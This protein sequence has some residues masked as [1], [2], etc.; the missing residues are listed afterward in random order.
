LSNPGAPV[1][2]LSK[3]IEI[4]TGL[5]VSQIMQELW[6]GAVVGALSGPTL[7]AEVDKGL[8]T[9]A[10]VAAAS[11]TQAAEFQK[12]LHQPKF[13]L[14]RSTDIP[15]VEMGGALKNVYAIAGGV[16]MGAGLGE[17]AF[18]GLMTRCLAEMTRI[19][20]KAGG[21]PETFSGLSGVGDLLLTAQSEQSRNHRVGRLLAAGKKLETA[22]KEAGGT[23]EG[24]HTAKAV[25][26][27]S[28]IPID[29]KPIL[30]QIHALLYEGK[31]VQK[32]IEELLAR[33]M[34]NEIN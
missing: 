32:A 29:S 3:G 9:V 5:R 8:P 18:A 13:R 15:G 6:P 20:V 25:F 24:V 17:N 19:G 12:L 34:K 7:A 23:V 16:C 14:Y 4:A 33:E 27:N 28:G 1:L 10:V 22:V 21:K 30:A 2:S 11:D 31:P 26:Q